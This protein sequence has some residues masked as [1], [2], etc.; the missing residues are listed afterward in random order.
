MADESSTPCGLD[1]PLIPKGTKPNAHAARGWYQNELVGG[2][3]NRQTIQSFGSSPQG[4]PHAAPTTS[5]PKRD[6]QPVEIRMGL[7]TI[8]K[9]ARK[10]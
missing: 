8:S 10:K 7:P 3:E 2:N 9:A 6:E 1:V 4:W 5:V